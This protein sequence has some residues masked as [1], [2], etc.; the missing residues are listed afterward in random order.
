MN[1]ERVFNKVVDIPGT[2]CCPHLQMGDVAPV[3]TVVTD[4]CGTIE[5]NASCLDCHKANAEAAENLTDY[6]NDCDGEFKVKDLLY[7]KSWGDTAEDSSIPVCP[8]CRK[9]G[10]HRKRVQEYNRCKAMDLADD[11]DE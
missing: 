11:A 2:D 4:T 8:N 5:I 7:F 9:G 6:C 3:I 10:V 1:I